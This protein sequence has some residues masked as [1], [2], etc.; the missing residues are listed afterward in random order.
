MA[1]RRLADPERA[2]GGRCQLLLPRAAGAPGPE[3]DACRRCLVPARR[4]ARE[5]HSRRPEGS[6]RRSGT[7]AR[8]ASRK[9]QLRRRQAGATEAG[10]GG[11]LMRRGF[12]PVGEE[13][14]ALVAGW[15]S[16][17][18]EKRRLFTVHTPIIPWHSERCAKC[19][20]RSTTYLA[21]GT[22]SSTARQAVVRSARAWHEVL[23]AE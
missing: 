22:Y 18:Q 5:H 14:R 6:R 2:A 19:I 10:A 17:P 9:G 20:I 15:D 23:G 4:A 12:A 13:P 11:D 3:P 8:G 7:R 21:R 16:H 1:A